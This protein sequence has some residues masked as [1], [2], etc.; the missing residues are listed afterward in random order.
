[1]ANYRI[2]KYV[3][4]KY[5]NKWAR[6]VYGG[7][8][9]EFGVRFT[10]TEHRRFGYRVRKANKAIDRYNAQYQTDSV[11]R[12]KEV[13][14]RYRSS[15]L[16]RFRRKS[17]YKNYLKVTE[18]II[19]GEQQYI[20]APRTYSNNLI[21]AL[22]NDTIRRLS[23]QNSNINKL[24]QRAI[25]KVKSLTNDQLIRLSR[26]AKTPQINENYNGN[27][28]II[29]NNLETLIEVIDNDIVGG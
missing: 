7:W 24:R 25:N 10:K 6:D 4:D 29:S 8:T 15:D 23:R 11:L 21:K 12:V 17:A 3:K 2:V 27:G 28:E 14:A 22:N 9:N 5:G 20:R 16:A 26:N 13:S 1:M 19:T 18:R